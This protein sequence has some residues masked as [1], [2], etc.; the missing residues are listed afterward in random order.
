MGWTI[1]RAFHPAMKEGGSLRQ[2]ADVL[3]AS[4]GS[5]LAS[6]DARSKEAGRVGEG[7]LDYYQKN[8][9]VLQRDK[10]YFK[11]WHSA[12]AIADTGSKGGHQLGRW[13]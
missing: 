8:T 4:V 9:P 10:K 13:S 2:L 5:V 3:K 12:L 11:T 1:S 6:T 7:A